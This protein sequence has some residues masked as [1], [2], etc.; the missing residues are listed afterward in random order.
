VIA[1]V[2]EAPVAASVG[3]V[4]STVTT[5][6]T[7]TT[8]VLQVPRRRRK[9]DTGAAGTSVVIDA[10]RRPRQHCELPVGDWPQ[11]QRVTP[12]VA[13]N[14]VAE[15]LKAPVPWSMDGGSWACTRRNTAHARRKSSCDVAR[16]EPVDALCYAFGDGI[17]EG[18]VV[19]QRLQNKHIVFIGDSVSE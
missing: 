3:E 18:D 5:A 6:P 1:D 13:A 17:V 15:P 14:I 19:R 8:V 4:A 12:A 11:L 7:T 2:G 10:P 16:F 9:A